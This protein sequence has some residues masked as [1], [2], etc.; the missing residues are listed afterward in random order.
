MTD[1]WTPSQPLR[2]DA[3]DEQIVLREQY[4]FCRSGR[5]ESLYELLAAARELQAATVAEYEAD[6]SS[7]ANDQMRIEK[8]FA[9]LPFGIRHQFGGDLA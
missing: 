7:G 5:K 4:L 6:A 3:S 2:A 9:I 1:D 8:L